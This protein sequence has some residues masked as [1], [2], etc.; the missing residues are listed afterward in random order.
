MADLKLLD[1]DGTDA[2]VKANSGDGSSGSP[3][4]LRRASEGLVAHDAVHSGNPS[5][6]GGKALSADPTAVASAD[7]VNALFDLIGRLVVA[8]YTIP[9]NLTRGQN[10]SPIT[11]TTSTQVVAAPAGS[12]RLFVT[13]IVAYNTSA[14]ATI[15]TLTDG[16]GGATLLSFNL[17]ATSGQMS[18]TLPA[19]LRLTAAT[20][21][22]AVCTTSG[23]SVTVSVVGYTGV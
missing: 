2:Y 1:A 22:H 7:A 4:V 15:V 14:T 9:Q 13:T 17:P 8:P 21:L 19:P 20:A 5:S 10:A 23:A 18:I 16:S 3:F 6:I 11:N 12:L